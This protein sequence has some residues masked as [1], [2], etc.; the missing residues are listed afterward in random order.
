MLFFIPVWE[1]GK[2]MLRV[3]R[4]DISYLRFILEGYDGLGF[5]TTTDPSRAEVVI[6]YPA[7]QEKL[8]AQVIDAMRS[9]GLIREGTSQ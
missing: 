1:M 5:V 7:R 9:E 6:T 3:N 8:L 2:M 4:D